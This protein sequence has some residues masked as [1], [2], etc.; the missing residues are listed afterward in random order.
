VVADRGGS[1]YEKSGAEVT[2]LAGLAEGSQPCKRMTGSMAR[3]PTGSAH[4]QPN[5]SCRPTPASRA[6]D[7]YE[8]RP[9][10]CGRSARA[11]RWAAAP[12][13][14]TPRRWI[15]L[16]GIM[17]VD[18]TGRGQLLPK[19]SAMVEESSSPGAILGV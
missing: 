12:W 19:S 1:K 4:H 17:G 15:C 13:L 2:L 14:P 9:S 3:A 16:K 11:G 7:R 18:L 6:S 8:H 10:P 5:S